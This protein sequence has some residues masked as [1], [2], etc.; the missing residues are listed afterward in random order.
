MELSKELAYILGALRDGSVLRYRDKQGKLHHYI[1]FY[2]KDQE[3]LKILSEILS[4]IFRE[5][6]TLYIPKT[7]TPYL[8]IYS[9]RIAVYFKEKFQH[10]LSSQIMWETPKVLKKTGNPEILKWYIAGFWD[11]EGSF[12][13]STKQL[14][15]H[16]SWNGSE[17]P[18]LNDIKD[19]LQTLGIRTGKVGRYVN[20][21]GNYPR[22]VLRVSKR[23]NEK[24][25]KTI[26]VLNP[27]K[28]RKIGISPQNSSPAEV[29]GPENGRD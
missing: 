18:P 17:C 15:F 22:F 20:K 7:G 27:F 19:F 4:R 14:R 23:D 5:K 6:Q 28:K 1:T 25:L 8:R 16:L 3:W 13:T 2:S 10:P 9:K 24:F 29:G 11:A 12:D 26:P 21:N